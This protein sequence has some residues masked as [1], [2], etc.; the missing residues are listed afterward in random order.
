MDDDSQRLLQIL[1]VVVFTT[2]FAFLFSMA[3]ASLG[4][5]GMLAIALIQGLVTVVITHYTQMPVTAMIVILIAQV[6][7][8]VFFAIG[9]VAASWRRIIA[10]QV[11]AATTPVEGH[12]H[13]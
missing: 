10:G 8:S 9:L 11:T 1:F 13:S 3:R 5:L 4:W 12:H 7:F 6:N 2:I